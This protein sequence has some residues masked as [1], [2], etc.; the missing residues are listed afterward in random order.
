MQYSVLNSK[1]CRVMSSRTIRR[2]FLRIYNRQ[3]IRLNDWARRGVAARAIRNQRR[4]LL[5]QIRGNPLADA[6]LTGYFYLLGATT[7]WLIVL[8]VFGHSAPAYVPMW[9]A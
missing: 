2:R 3:V 6:V 8:N 9:F 1:G 4:N 7:L 5:L